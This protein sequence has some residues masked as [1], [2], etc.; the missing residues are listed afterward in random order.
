MLNLIKLELQFTGRGTL[1][2]VMKD[3]KQSFKIENGDVIRVPAGATTYLINNHTTENLSLV[4]LFQP[5]NTPDLFEVIKFLF[6]FSFS[7]FYASY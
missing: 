7:N 3:T 1:T 2:L 5:V 4:H 6:L